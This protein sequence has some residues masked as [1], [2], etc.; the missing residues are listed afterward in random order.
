MLKWKIVLLPPTFEKNQFG[1]IF[2]RDEN[3][4][5]IEV[6]SISLLRI[7]FLSQYHNRPLRLKRISLD[8]FFQG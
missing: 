8:N 1:I 7:I 5:P 3:C 2:S 6:I 4:R